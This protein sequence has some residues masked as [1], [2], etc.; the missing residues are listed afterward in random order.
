MK[1]VEA[2]EQ[3]TLFCPLD[4]PYLTD[5]FDDEFENAYMRAEDSGLGR[6]TLPARFLWNT[7]M[8]TEIESGGPSIMFKDSI[9][10]ASRLNNSSNNSPKLTE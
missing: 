4:V 5:S 9:N 1:R 8:E 3:W 7:I 2:D 6:K 10:S